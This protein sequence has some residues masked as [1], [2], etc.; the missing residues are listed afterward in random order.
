MKSMERKR[1]IITVIEIYDK[2]FFNTFQRGYTKMSYHPPPPP[3][4][5]KKFHPCPR[6]TTATNPKYAFIHATYPDPLIKNAHTTPTSQNIPL[7][8]RTSS[9]H[10]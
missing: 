4:P 3:Q 10:C 5:K 1:S 6:Y 8:L 2:K 9:K 7:M